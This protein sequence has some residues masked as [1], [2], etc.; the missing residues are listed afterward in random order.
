[1]I[2]AATDPQ[3]VY[4][5]PAGLGQQW[6]EGFDV[7]VLGFDVDEDPRE[8]LAP[9]PQVAA[10]EV[11]GV[12]DVLPPVVVVRPADADHDV[13]GDAVSDLR[14]S[15]DEGDGAELECAVAAKRQPFSEAAFA[16]RPLVFSGRIDPL[17]IGV[18]PQVAL[19]EGGGPDSEG[20]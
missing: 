6:P 13:V 8:Q 17:L 7:D 5:T 19:A 4:P 9:G 14:R 2:V 18:V 20:S 3:H 16:H 15:A 1:M 10:I 12:P 11:L